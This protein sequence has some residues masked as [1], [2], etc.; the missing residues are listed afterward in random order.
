MTYMVSHFIDG[1]KARSEAEPALN[2][3]NPALGEVCGQVAVAS[4]QEIEEAILVAKK[5][6][7]TWSMTPPLRR[8]RVLFKFKDLLE[9]HTDE[10]AEII[11]REHGK[12]ISDAK[13]EIARGIEL[14]EFA[15]GIP[16]LLKGSFSENV[17][18]EVD[19]YTVRQALGV[20]LGVSPFNFPVMVPI[21]MCIPAI[22]CGNTFIL[23]PSEK[24]PSAPLRLAELLLEA[25][26]PP[27]VL[28]V[29]NGG[30]EVVDQLLVHPAIAAVSCVG[31]T[32][33]AEHI[34]RT[35]TAQGKRAHTFGGAKNHCV[36]MPDADLD[37][38][39]DSICNA[40]YGAA[41]ERCMA[42]SVAVVV[43]DV[44]ADA[45][46]KKMQQQ[47]AK[48]NI[49]PGN[50]AQSEMGPLVTKE[51]LERVKNYVTLGAK[52]GAELVIDGRDYTVQ[53]YEHG[54]FMGP[55]L[56]DRV[57][58]QMRIYKEEIFGPVLDVVRVATL[59]QA[60]DLINQHEFGNGTAIFTK[61]GEAGR[62]FAVR[63][64]V[65]MVG[66]NIPIPVPVAYHAFGGWKRSI[67]GDIHMHGEES[68]K[69]Y[70]KSKTV[71]TKWPA[72]K[73]GGYSMPH[74]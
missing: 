8:A 53:G 24:D 21:W 48:I 67:F 25:G 36:V 13:G 68:I 40:A 64:Q 39:A 72:D 6:Y 65:G 37:H 73:S 60:I 70:T 52:E 33:V 19:S 11:S 54:Y 47:I 51:H 57:T 44:T 43:G 28:N 5:A 3:Y 55:S 20:C 56:F 71:T 35:A 2:L 22:A 32:P 7:A 34:Y 59:D 45:L 69:F 49:G 17:S 31:S 58:P 12:V 46:I 26:L 41:G 50:H 4:T 42:L 16:H 29:L 30:K 10:L 63:V 27:G 18:A 61:S 66:I 15:C 23:K 74:N 1:K 38:A 62:E 9:E 14:V